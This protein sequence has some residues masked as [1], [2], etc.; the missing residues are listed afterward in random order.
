MRS[1]PGAIFGSHV[2]V[3]VVVLLVGH[4][5]DAVHEG[6]RVGEVGEGEGLG[7]MVVMDRRPAATEAVEQGAQLTALQRR[8]TTT[9]RNTL[10][11]GQIH[12]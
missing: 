3:G 7:Q 10:L 9:T 11:A 8:G 5:A 4:G 6:K 2:G 1:R 12:G